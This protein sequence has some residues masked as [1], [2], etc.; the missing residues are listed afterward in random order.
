[1]KKLILGLLCM[2]LLLTAACAENTKLV[3]CDEL[4][5][6]LRIPEKSSMRIRLKL[7]S[8]S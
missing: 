5:I 3:N 2:F 7:L 6:V 1:M 8:S 4:G